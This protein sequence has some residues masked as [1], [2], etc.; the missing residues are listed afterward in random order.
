MRGVIIQTSALLILAYSAFCQVSFLEM[1]NELNVTDIDDSR[2]AA[3]IDLNNDDICE[4]VIVNKYGQNRLYMWFDSLYYD[5]GEEYG[6]NETDRHHCITVADVDKDS[7]PDLYITGDQGD[8]DEAHYF[9]N[10]GYPPFE[11]VAVDYNLNTVY[12]M[13]SAFFQ[14][15]PHTSLAG[16]CGGRL[17]IRVE[18]T[19]IDVTQGS[20]LESITNVFCP[21]FYDI[22]RDGDVDL[23]AAGNHESHT[24]R[25][26]RNNGDSTFTDISTN[27]NE[28]QFRIGQTAAFGDIDNDGDFDLY[29]C[30]GFGTN[31]MWQN[32]GTGFFTNITDLSNTGVGG[33]TR[34][35]CFGDYDNDGD[36]DLF[37]NRATDYNIL[38]LN[39]GNGIFTDYSQEAGVTDNLNGMGA[40]SGDLNND[41]QLDIVAVNCDYQPTQVYINQNQNSSFLKVRAV[42][43]QKNSLALGAIIEL[44]GIIENPLDTVLIGIRQI[45]SETS[46]L[47][48]DD[49]TAHFGTGIYENLHIHLTFPSLGVVDIFDIYPGQTITIHESLTDIDESETGLPSKFLNIDAYPNPFNSSVKISFTGES[50]NQYSLKI[51][52]MLGRLV[53]SDII[54]NNNMNSYS[55]FWNATDDLDQPVPSGIYFISV[56]SKEYASSI[57]VTLLK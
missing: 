40:A 37:L 16:L 4:I 20:G 57:K 45:A 17:M 10:Y 31:T 56:R 8:Y 6:I 19:F 53:K 24:G 12:E 38:F 28:G 34:A 13:G 5:V 3:I 18:D 32:D 50:A 55:Y 44:Y 51:F 26:F 15:A 1:A 25:L 11:D 43:Q 30:S 41:G 54:N 49:L 29:V 9:L 48:V 2:G 35:A 46:G 42:G 7:N 52:D 33:Y 21:L 36:L 39:N 47:S 23:Y 27:S 22:D 14:L